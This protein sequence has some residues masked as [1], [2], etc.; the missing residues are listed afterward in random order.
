MSHSHSAGAPQRLERALAQGDPTLND[1]VY[2]LRH[3]RALIVGLALFGAIAAVA[4]SFL[5]TPRYRSNTLL[6]PVQSEDLS[7]L[8]Q[9]AGSLGGLASLTGLSPPSGMG[10]SQ[11]SIA[12]LRSRSFIKSFIMEH[13][14]MRQLFA[15]E[16]DEARAAW[17]APDDA[18][19]I[20]DAVDFFTEEV[21]HISEDRVSGM[22]TL[23]VDWHDPKIAADW[24]GALV[25][26][27]N[28]T[29]R[30]RAISHAQ[31]SLAY[32]DAE[33][34]R[35]GVMEVRQAIFRMMEGEIKKQMLANVQADF[36][37]EIID[38]PNIPDPQK[39]VF[40][41]HKVFGALGLMTGTFAGFALALAHVLLIN[42][43]AS[44]PNRSLS[45][46]DL[47]HERAPPV[48]R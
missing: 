34:N 9:L 29:M 4:L 11:V 24:A 37:F 2:V 42:G 39:Y 27:L 23:S 18:P 40:P 6:L 7:G 48:T 32:L 33:L 8:D 12:M 35:V 43:K 26:R 5:L 13:D 31:R 14:L 16:W 47:S 36:A 1:L 22:V 41:D 19:S 3:Y 25:G 17:T 15:D 30:E 45:C 38:P 10:S 28:R 20:A 21:M 44:M 46:P